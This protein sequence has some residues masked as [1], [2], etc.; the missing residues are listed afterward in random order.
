MSSNSGPH[1]QSWLEAAQEVE[2][3]PKAL[4]RCPSCAQ[5]F[6]E[7]IDLK[8]VGADRAYEEQ[9]LRCSHCGT[10]NSILKKVPRT[11]PSS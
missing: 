6:L 9:I 2:K 8:A 5:G 4:V 1:T 11:R 7:V 3:D 10:W